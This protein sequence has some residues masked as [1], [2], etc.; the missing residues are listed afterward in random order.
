[1]V[2]LDVRDVVKIFAQRT[3]GEATQVLALDG[4]TF[5]VRDREVV[6]V[7]GPSGCGK[8]TLL[9]L[10]AG[11][12]FPTRGEIILDGAR[13]MGPNPKIGF[14]LQKDLLLP[15]KTVMDNVEL[16]QKIRRVPKE[17][18]MERTMTLL[19]KYG[20]GE[21]SHKYP[22]QLSGGMRQRVALARTMAIDPEILLLDEPF[23]ALDFQTRLLLQQDLYNILKESQKTVV[24][25]T[26]DIAEA[27]VMSN[28]VLVMTK[29]PG[30]IKMDLPVELP[31]TDDL[32]VRR[33]SKEL[34]EYFQI[35][36]ENLEHH[37]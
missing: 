37:L 33:R 6:G 13:V 4:V 3:G 34:S 35:I 32:M 31:Q 8:S 14:M 26:H 17:I 5:Q 25:I 12:I 9:G 18:R 23:S 27:L 21:F 16:G 10:V 28:R 19:N 11:L 36:W 20:L 29:R 1:M 2:R 7:V 30:K 22:W 24:L 15:W